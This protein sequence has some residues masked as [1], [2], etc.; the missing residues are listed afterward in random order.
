MEY[1]KDTANTIMYFK[2]YRKHISTGIVTVNCGVFG[3]VEKQRKI[4]QS[5]QMV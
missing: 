1:K 4:D 2:R 3:T 5:R